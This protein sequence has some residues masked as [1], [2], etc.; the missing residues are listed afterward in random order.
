[1]LVFQEKLRVN[2]NAEVVSFKLR[3]KLFVAVQVKGVHEYKVSWVAL[4]SQLWL[5]NDIFHVQ[6]TCL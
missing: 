1:M 2:T 6:S 4:K 5:Q 3:C